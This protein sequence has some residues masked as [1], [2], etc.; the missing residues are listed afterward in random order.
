MLRIGE[1][2]D[3]DMVKA[4][5]GSHSPLLAV[6][7]GTRCNNCLAS[8][9]SFTVVFGNASATIWHTRLDK[10][11]AHGARAHARTIE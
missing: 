7:L 11:R 2:E 8:V 9:L 5:R 6:A 3:R 1:C 10:P 4:M